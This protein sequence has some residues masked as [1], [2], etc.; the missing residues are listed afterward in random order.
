MAD[1]SEF[2]R[3]L[4]GGMR[5]LPYVYMEVRRSVFEGAAAF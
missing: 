2:H 3:T 1:D 5:K 4:Y